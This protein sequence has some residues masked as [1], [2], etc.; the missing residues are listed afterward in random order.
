MNY[1]SKTGLTQMR[2]GEL[3]YIILKNGD[4]T[5]IIT[6]PEDLDLMNIARS[7]RFDFEKTYAM[8]KSNK[9]R[10]D[11]YGLII[12]VEVLRESQ[13]LGKPRYLCVNCGRPIQINSL[14]G[15]QVTW[16]HVDVQKTDVDGIGYKR[17]CKTTYA[18]PDP[19]ERFVS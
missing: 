6:A 14:G 8:L 10:S 5:E 7:H 18:Y 2:F 19:V 13:G 15:D 4:E 1:D 11:V 17:P 9:D 12:D 16:E 3:A